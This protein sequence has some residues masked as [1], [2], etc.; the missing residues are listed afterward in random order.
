MTRNGKIARLPLEIRNRLG[1]R[2][3][4]GEVGKTLVSWLNSLSEVKH[5]MHQEF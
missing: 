1:R 5:V 2:L 4:N 3:Q